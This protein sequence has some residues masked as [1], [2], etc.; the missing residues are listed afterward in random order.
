MWLSGTREQ[1][2]QFT[3]TATTTTERIEPRIKFSGP[4]LSSQE[5]E[6]KERVIKE[7]LAFECPLDI[8]SMYRYKQEDNSIVVD[9]KFEILQK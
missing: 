4:V 7:N 6:T 8:L 2:E 3:W 1:A 9:F 5:E